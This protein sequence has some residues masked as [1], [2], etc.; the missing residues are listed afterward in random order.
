[1]YKIRIDYMDKEND[2]VTSIYIESENEESAYDRMYALR[3]M[4]DNENRRYIVF[5]KKGIFSKYH[6]MYTINDLK[7]D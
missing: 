3:E 5:V 2:V 1:M 7:A 4:L 6:R